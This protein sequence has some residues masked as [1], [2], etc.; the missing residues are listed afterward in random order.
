MLERRFI[1]LTLSTAFVGAT[2]GVERSVLPLL[3]SERFGIASRTAIVSF[4]IA[5]GLAKAAA[6]L[7]SGPL[8]GR[9]G[10]TRLLV[11]G[12]L[13]G[14]AVPPLILAAPTWGWVIAANALLGISQGFCWSVALVGQVE[15]AGERR[16]GAAAG[17]NEFAGYGGA[18]LAAYGAAAL[19]AVSGLR[20]APFLLMQGLALGGLATSLF[21]FGGERRAPPGL[22]FDSVFRRMSGADLRLSLLS[23]SGLVTNLSDGL[24]WGL[25][26]LVFAHQGRSLVEIGAL[27]AVYPATWATMQLAAGWASDRLGRRRLIVWGLT[28]Q[29]GSV[30]LLASAGTFLQS[31][32]CMLGLGLGTAL[33][34]PTLIA[35]VADL[36]SPAERPSAIGTYRLW[37]D[38][39]YVAGALVSG[40][41]ADFVG[42]A[43]SIWTVAAVTGVMALLTRV[44]LPGALWSLTRDKVTT[45]RSVSGN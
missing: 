42:F 27:A 40:A 30:G 15:I 8:S 4:L 38:L 41:L 6:N 13:I 10:A 24:A 32:A 39:G 29:A 11:A 37:R 12:W 33:V 45:W 19:A 3:G 1:V 21:A 26:P 34:Y 2:I 43:A 16:R 22:R 44:F 18:A 9:V 28:V 14:A 23:A 5:F 25:L 35:A 36:V 20:T 7:A 31:M 17:I